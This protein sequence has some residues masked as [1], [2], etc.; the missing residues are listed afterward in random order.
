M[1]TDMLVTTDAYQ[2]KPSDNAFTVKHMCTRQTANLLWQ[3]KIL[4][5]YCTLTV[6]SCN[7]QQTLDSRY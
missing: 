4:H 2:L 1:N 7:I 6:T 3:C 5:A